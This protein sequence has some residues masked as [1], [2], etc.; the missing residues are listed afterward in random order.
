MRRD[1]GT[2][3]DVYTLSVNLAIG[4]SDKAR[5]SSRERSSGICLMPSARFLLG[6]VF[7]RHFEAITS[8][9]CQVYSPDTKSFVAMIKHTRQTTAVRRISSNAVRTES[10]SSFARI[11]SYPGR[12][13]LTIPQDLLRSVCPVP[14]EHR[15]SRT[16][17]PP[18][19]ARL[20]SSRHFDIEH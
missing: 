15:R 5:N 8:S 9:A 13:R 6:A 20:K 7:I 10:L 2:P 11:I 17:H 12:E 14:N 1:A 19:C 18:P 4:P 16:F 3:K